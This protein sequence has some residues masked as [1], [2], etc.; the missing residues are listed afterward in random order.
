[1]IHGRN[2]VKRRIVALV[3]GLS[4][5]AGA[6]AGVVVVAEPGPAPVVV[7]GSSWT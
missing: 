2:S 3:L 1:M 5:F 6:V 7:A 4:A